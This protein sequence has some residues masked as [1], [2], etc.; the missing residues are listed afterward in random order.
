[1]LAIFD[2]DGVLV[3]SEKLAAQTFSECL[4]AIDINLSAADCM[5]K[6]KGS[7]LKYCYEQIEQKFSVLLPKNFDADL[8]RATQKNFEQNLRAVEGVA[9]L[10]QTLAE[11]NIA[12]CVASNG[13]QEKIAHSLSIA[14]L[15]NWF[16][17]ALRFSAYDCVQGKPSPELFLKAAESMGVPNS[18]C[19]V[20]EDSLA[21]AQAA[22]S[23]NMQLIYFHPDAEPHGEAWQNCAD[24]ESVRKALSL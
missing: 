5:E 8:R 16:P 17:R 10:V 21:G 12:Y 6:F 24:M 19:Y 9:P 1:M 2:C 7:T 4:A 23:A 14:G 18:F 3:D 13:S 11:N 20:I 22:L 15:E